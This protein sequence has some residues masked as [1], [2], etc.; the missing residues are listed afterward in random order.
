MKPTSTTIDKAAIGLSLICAVHCLLLPVALVMLPALAASTFGDERFHQ[1]LLIVVLPTSLIALTMGCRQHQNTSV[2]AMGLPGLIVLTLAA[3]FG[4]D[5]GEN[6]EKIASLLGASLIA[7]AHL[8]NH[9]LCRSL[10]CDCEAT[11]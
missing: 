8:R 11:W 5:L 6:G 4:H 10:H 2:I 9:T 1:S 3:F 7:L